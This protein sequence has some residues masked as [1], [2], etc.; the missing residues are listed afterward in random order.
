MVY[1]TISEILHKIDCIEICIFNG[2]LVLHVTM[3]IFWRRRF[4]LFWQL[5]PSGGAPSLHESMTIPWPSLVIQPPFSRY[6]PSSH[7]T[8]QL[9]IV[10]HNNDV[11]HLVGIE[12][13]SSGV[14]WHI[15]VNGKQMGRRHA[16]VNRLV[17]CNPLSKG[18]CQVGVLVT[19]PTGVFSSL[20]TITAEIL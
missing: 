1:L 19:I 6:I 15:F 12:N 16:T 17:K 11:M 2:I 9:S 10:F 18:T 3:Y 7:D 13:G 4:G 8:R 20:T 5:S 14:M